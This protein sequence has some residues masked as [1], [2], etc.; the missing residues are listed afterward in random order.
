MESCGYDLF[1]FLARHSSVFVRIDFQSKTK[2]SCRCELIFGVSLKGKRL[3]ED[4]HWRN[5]PII[6]VYKLSLW[7]LFY[8]LCGLL[9]LS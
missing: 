3:G 8:L 1:F 5:R 4:M 2:A 6:P 7:F 9:R